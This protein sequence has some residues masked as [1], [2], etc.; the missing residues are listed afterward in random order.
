MT[1]LIINASKIN[2]FIIIY[3][4]GGKGFLD[5]NL[6]CKSLMFFQ[7]LPRMHLTKKKVHHLYHLPYCLRAKPH[8]Q[9]HLTAQVDL[10]KHRLCR[11]HI[12]WLPI[13]PHQY[14]SLGQQAS[15]PNCHPQHKRNS[16]HAQVRCLPGT[17]HMFI[18]IQ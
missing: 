1:L 18:N 2:F 6:P 12:Q 10:S 7:P 9:H 5:D 8:N 17:M 4:S 16:S 13:T 15:L 14:H 11:H 3:C